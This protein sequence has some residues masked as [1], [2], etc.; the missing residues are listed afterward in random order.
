MAYLVNHIEQRSDE[1]DEAIVTRRTKGLPYA[2]SIVAGNRQNGT[3]AAIQNVVGQIREEETPILEHHRAESDAW[4]MTTGSF[5]AVFFLLTAV[6]FTLCGVV[7]KMALTSQ[8]QAE[9]FLQ[10]FSRSS[11]TPATR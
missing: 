6:V 4:A 10:T 2:K 11:T 5:A 8:A 3:M 9:R 1:M 7:M